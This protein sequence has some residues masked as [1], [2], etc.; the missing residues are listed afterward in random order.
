[1]ALVIP[2]GF[3]Q[4][5]YRFGLNTDPE[6]MV[7]TI[8]VDIAFGATGPQD[9]VDQK[10]DAFAAAV[11]AASLAGGYTFLGC[12]LREGA[13]GGGSVI[14]EAPRAIVGVA[15]AV[16]LPNNCAFLVR[17]GTG[18][19]GRRGRGRMYLPPYIV[20]EADVTNTGMLSPA[21]LVNLQGVVD[22]AFPGDDFVLLHDSLPS[23]IPP[24]PV[25]SLVV[26]RQIATQRRRMRN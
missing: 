25:T 11:P 13:A 4:L 16:S 21:A 18:R 5:A 6:I 8:G 17:K 24:D 22:A 15:A 14:Y 7:T 1:M 9:K 20:A 26:D 10:A 2:P 19:A 23:V 3:G 12:I